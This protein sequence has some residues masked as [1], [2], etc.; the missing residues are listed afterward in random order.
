VNG[1]LLSLKLSK[2][3]AWGNRYCRQCWMTV[4]QCLLFCLSDTLSDTLKFISS[5]TS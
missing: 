1:W 2:G 4:L 3:Q 5:H